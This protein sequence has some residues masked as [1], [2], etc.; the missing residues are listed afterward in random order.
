M[1]FLT[2]K[3]RNQMS[4]KRHLRDVAFLDN[5]CQLTAAKY[6]L[7]VDVV[8]PDQEAVW[9]IRSRLFIRNGKRFTPLPSS[10]FWIYLTFLSSETLHHPSSSYPSLSLE[11]DFA[12]ESR[13]QRGGARFS[14]FSLSL[15]FSE[16]QLNGHKYPALPAHP[17]F[18]FL[19]L[20]LGGGDPGLEL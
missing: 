15:L 1:R 19:G 11:R 18:L 2:L 16:L 20:G 14:S 3:E 7:L 5:F 9:M 6:L 12:C 4:N 13:K 8:A 10:R 17:R